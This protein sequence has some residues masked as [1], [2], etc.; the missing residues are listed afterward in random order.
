MALIKIIRLLIVINVRKLFWN[1]YLKRL[2]YYCWVD[3]TLQYFYRP[4]T[5][6]PG[7]TFS[8]RWFAG[9]LGLKHRNW[10]LDWIKHSVAWLN[11]TK[12]TILSMRYLLKN[13]NYSREL[14]FFDVVRAG[15]RLYSKYQHHIIRERMKCKLQ[16]EN[17]KINV[18]TG[19]FF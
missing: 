5:T 9:F 2:S 7:F 18:W 8:L 10:T 13:R 16:G 14:I 12:Q 4:T 11:D 6:I 15:V 1:V 19:T 17:Q 3:Y